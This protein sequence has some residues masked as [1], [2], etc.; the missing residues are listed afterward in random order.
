M[1]AS[2]LGER[3]PGVEVEPG[4]LAVTVRYP[5]SREIQVLP[6]LATKTGLR[7]ANADGEGWSNVVR[8]DAFARKLTAV[9]REN[10]SRVVPM[11]KL[12][13][14][15]IEIA[16]PATVKPTGYHAESLAIEA[17]ATYDGPLNSKAMLRHLC[18]T[19]VERVR[20]PIADRTGQSLH[21]DDYLGAANSRARSVLAARL[22]RLAKRIEDADRRGDAEAWRSLLGGEA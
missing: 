20:T 16:L 11:I 14:G 6:A 2:R 4:T 17:F 7:I 3:L 12:F 18:R 15:I 9:N 13:K 21:V 1:F 19:A 5:D 8:P 22:D 10:G